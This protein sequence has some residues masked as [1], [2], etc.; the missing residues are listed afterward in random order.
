M[1]EMANQEAT[2]FDEFYGPSKWKEEILSKWDEF[3]HKVYRE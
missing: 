3:L 1:G 2:R